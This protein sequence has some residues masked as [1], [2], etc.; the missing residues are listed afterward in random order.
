MAG[1]DELIITR[2]FN[3]SKKDLFNAWT[4]PDLLKK[5]WGPEGFSCPVA[6][7]DLKVGGKYVYCMR[8]E[9]GDFKGKDFWSGGEYKKIDAPNKLIISDYF[10]DKNGNKTDPTAHGLDKN[11]PKE[12][13]VTITFTEKNGKTTLKTSY[14]LPKSK[15]ARESIKKSRMD[16]GWNSSLNKLQKLVENKTKNFKMKEFVIKRTFNTDKKT[17][18]QAFTNEK[19]MRQWWGP[20]EVDVI[21]SEMNLK[22]GGKYHYC[23]QNYNG[24]RNWGRMVFK[25]I[26]KPDK[27]VF[28][29][30][31]SNE[32]GELTRAPFPGPWPL[33]MLTTMTFTEK[34]GKTTVN[35]SWIPINNTKEEY[36]VFDKGRDGMVTGWTGS[37]DRLDKCIKNFQKKRGDRC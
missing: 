7:I 29:N 28:I 8:G 27:L 35:I 5:W 15:A 19:Y 3:A 13:L 34:N 12:S 32:K 30:S 33:E 36:N 17:L 6:R 16:E 21:H 2:T 24:E 25:E 18:W 10:C 11:F 9:I 26:C 20:K 23:M 31:F 1:K 22:V 37:L 14:K 4:N